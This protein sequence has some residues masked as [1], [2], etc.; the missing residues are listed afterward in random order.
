MRT[1]V[2]S[3][4]RGDA[5]R[6]GW[7]TEADLLD[8][9]RTST[10]E[11]RAVVADRTRV[12]LVAKT[13][14]GDV[15]GCAVV[16]R[17]GPARA[18]FGLFAVRPTGQGAGLGKRILAA[19]EAHAATAWGATMMEM[20]VITRR[21]ELIAFYVRRGYR[22]TGRLTPLTAHHDAPDW[23]LGRDLTLETFEKAIAPAAGTVLRRPAQ[24]PR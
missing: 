13:A 24:R 22:P 10:D 2:E 12:I 1:L 3:A 7:T 11:L 20:S 9:R 5:S 8:G 17:A 21:E 6:A 4:D 23:T 16:A 19:A 18:S 14:D 15:A